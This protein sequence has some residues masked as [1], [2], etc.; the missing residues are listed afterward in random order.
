[1][2]YDN[3]KPSKFVVGQSVD[4]VFL[5]DDK[6]KWY[7]GLVKNVNHYGEDNNGT[8]VECK[9]EYEDG[10]IVDDARFYDCDFENDDSL[11]SWRFSSSLNDVLEALDEVKGDLEVLQNKCV[12][13]APVP[14]IVKLAFFIA[15]AALIN[16]AYIYSQ[17]ECERCSRIC[18][19][20]SSFQNVMRN[21]TLSKQS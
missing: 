9:V 12:R 16:S 13:A 4:V 6:S 3:I 2:V 10:D 21:L 19:L 14:F 15:A 7:K 20:A 8:Y 1:M 18:E 11:D 5:E 17:D